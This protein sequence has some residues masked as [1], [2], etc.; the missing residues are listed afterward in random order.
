MLDTDQF[1][2]DEVLGK[3]ASGEVYLAH[4]STG[5]KVAVKELLV[6]NLV[7]QKRIHSC[8]EI[9]VSSRCDHPF[10]VPLIGFSLGSPFKIVSQY[11]SKG[12]LCTA[13]HKN[14]MHL[15]RTQRTLIAMG[16]AS[17]MAHLHEQGI[18]HRDLKSLNVLLDEQQGTLLPRVSDF[19]I[20][21]FIDSEEEGPLTHRIGTLPGLRRK[22]LLPVK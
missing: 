16:I 21:R 7:G 11:M 1:I 17:G 20:S 12:T 9:R 19:G 6:E 10:L 4:D 22:C 15:T 18:I 14:P 5:R 8:R 3:G 13:L 2:K